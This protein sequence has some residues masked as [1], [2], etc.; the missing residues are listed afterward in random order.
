MFVCFRFLIWGVG[1]K[2]LRKGEVGKRKKRRERKVR[3]A[4]FI[5]RKGIN[6]I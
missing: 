6:F 3:V 5:I 4:A 1:G 2:K